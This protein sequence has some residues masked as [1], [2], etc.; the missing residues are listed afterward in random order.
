MSVSFC[1]LRVWQIA[2]VFDRFS[3]SPEI[4]CRSSVYRD[5]D[6][7]L[8][9]ARATRSPQCPS[10]SLPSVVSTPRVASIKHLFNKQRLLPFLRHNVNQDNQRQ[11]KNTLARNSA[12]RFCQATSNVRHTS[13]RQVPRRQNR[14]RRRDNTERHT[15][16]HAR[17]FFCPRSSVRVQQHSLVHHSAGSS[18][19]A[20]SYG[21]VKHTPLH[22]TFT[23]IF[24]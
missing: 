8:A 15:R 12:S 3:C 19:F 24:S 6:D 10:V 14:A 5:S 17:T 23:D 16:T 4:C 7:I 9:V 13:A 2:V 20:D 21:D 18:S 1:D 11:R 22:R